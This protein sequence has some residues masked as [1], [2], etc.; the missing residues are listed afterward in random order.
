MSNK[1][2][3]TTI[4]LTLFLITAGAFAP[5]SQAVE[6]SADIRLTLD[7]NS[8]SSPSITQTI[9]GNIWAVWSSYR[10]DNTEIFYKVYNGSSWSDATPLT[11]NSSYDGHPAIIGAGDGKI[12]VVW[13]SDRIGTDNYEIFY[14]VYDGSWSD[15]TPLTNYSYWDCYPAI[16]E[17]NDGNIWVV[18]E[19]DR[20]EQD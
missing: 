18:W 14:K 7:E 11:A 6:W 8:D 1:I 16:M 13:V 15:A 12:W 9:D 10:T 5:P 2:T 17:D 3:L 4:I 19:S 20:N